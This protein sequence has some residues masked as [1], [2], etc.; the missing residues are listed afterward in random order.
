M[1]RNRYAFLRMTYACEGTDGPDGYRTLF[2]GGLFDAPPWQHPRN[3]VSAGGYTSTAAGAP[4]ILAGTWDDFCKDRGVRPFDPEGQDACAVWLIDRRGATADVD[5]GR[6]EQAIAKCGKEW[7]S[8]PGSPYGQRTRSMD[9]CRQHYLAAGGT[10]AD[11]TQPAAPIDDH[12]TQIGSEPTQIGSAD[13]S[14]SVTQGGRVPFLPIMLSLLPSVLN[15]FAPR[16]QAA[17]QKVTQQPPDVV[18]GFV[19]SLFDKLGQL[20]G[21]TDP[22]QATAAITKDPAADKVADLQEHAL[23]YLDKLS[24]VLEKLAGFDQLVWQAE[25]GSRTAAAGRGADLQREGVWSNPAFIVAI[26]IL[27]MVGGVVFTVLYRDVVFSGSIAFSSDMQSFVIG[28]VVG[29]AFTAV[30]SFFFG[31][32]RSSS[33]KDVLIGEMARQSKG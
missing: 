20:T 31:S 13:N 1:T 28:A 4:Q 7:A 14:N 3:K 33:A 5:A 21:T 8:F 25:E 16:A 18:Q 22:V 2:G 27:L 24:P 32:S 30:V 12:S 29:S 26:L 23:D 11:D 9:F 17:L 10:L 6:L 15:L 19:Q